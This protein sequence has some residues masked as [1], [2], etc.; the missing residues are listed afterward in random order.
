MSLTFFSLRPLDLWNNWWV[1]YAHVLW[2]L[3]LAYYTEGQGEILPTTSINHKTKK[4]TKKNRKTRK[5]KKYV[6]QAVTIHTTEASPVFRFRFV[7][8]IWKEER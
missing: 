4:K 6:C 3:T 1:M 5:Q 2:Q 7:P 8:S